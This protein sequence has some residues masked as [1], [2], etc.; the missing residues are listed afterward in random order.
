MFALLLGLSI[1]PAPVMSLEEMRVLGTTAE[2]NT[3][4]PGEIARQARRSEVETVRT[5]VAI[6]G[7]Q[8][9]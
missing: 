5:Q 1:L 6:A 7:K 4:L 8:H 3:D 9:G 2:G